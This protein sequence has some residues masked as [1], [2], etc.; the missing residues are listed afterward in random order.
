MLRHPRKK[1]L[2]IIAAG[3]SQCLSAVTANGS[4]L[5]GY[6]QCICVVAI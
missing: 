6:H 3:S 4:G 1:V 2:H 5:P